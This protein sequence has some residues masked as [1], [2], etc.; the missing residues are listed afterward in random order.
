MMSARGNVGI[1]H[2]LLEAGA[3]VNS[4]GAFG[5]TPLMWAAAQGRLEL[6]KLLLK[7]GA[8]VK[9]VSNDRL[10]ALMFAS[11][12]I[13]VEE[14]GEFG[15]SWSVSSEGGNNQVVSFL[16]KNGADIS[17]KDRNGRT[18]LFYAKKKPHD[19]IMDML[20]SHGAKE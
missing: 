11:G 12:P 10:T 4:K 5:I 1:C 2:L 14:K 9:A 3:E 7:Y 20:L 16:L 13:T 18:A 19:R 8:D 6:V 15:S 17:A